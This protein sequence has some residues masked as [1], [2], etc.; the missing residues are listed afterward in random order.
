[1]FWYHGD[2]ITPP[3]LPPSTCP[4]RFSEKMKIEERCAAQYF[5]FT[6]DFKTQ[7]KKNARN[8]GK[9]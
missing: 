6:G 3:P 5:E 7:L 2:R 8:A 9:I 4:Q 1:M